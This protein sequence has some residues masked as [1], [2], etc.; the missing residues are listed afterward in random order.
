[1]QEMKENPAKPEGEIGSAMLDRMNRSHAPLRN[2]AFPHIQWQPDMQILDVGC[3]GGAAISEMLTLSENSHICG[4]DYSEVSVA[5]AKAFNS[6][7]SAERLEI[8]QADIISLPFD[9]NR[10]ELV[11]AVETVYFWPEIEKA[12]REIYRV[13]KPYGEIA[14]LNEGSDPETSNWKVDG[15]LKVY[16][17]EELTSLLKSAGF[18][19]TRYYRG[20]GEYIFVTARK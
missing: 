13:L 1:M 19:G 20:E 8:L 12:F 2:W 15:F 18:Q 3:G 6:E 16:R 4:I 11:T 14:I 7:V 10:F 5:S 9:D 17:P